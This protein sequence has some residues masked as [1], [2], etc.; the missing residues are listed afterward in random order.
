MRTVLVVL[1]FVA[2]IAACSF[3]ADADLAEGK[4][5]EFH[6]L[7]DAGNA[8]AIY[9]A[10]ADDLKK[11][12]SESDFVALVN[13]IHR[14]LGPVKSTAK[15]AWQSSHM[16]AGTFVTLTYKTQFAEGEAT[17]RFVY[18]LVGDQATLAGYNIN[19]LALVT[20]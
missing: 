14:K 10:S 5:P 17:E 11:S 12:V 9:A 8:H 7:L 15:P 18:R 6:A 13:A 19:S 16:P 3:S 1:L 4:V 20:K 2:T